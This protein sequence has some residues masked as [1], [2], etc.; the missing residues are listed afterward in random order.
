MPFV[1]AQ[2]HEHQDKKG[3]NDCNKYHTKKLDHQL[4]LN[5]Q[6]FRHTKEMIGCHLPASF[7]IN[8]GRKSNVQAIEY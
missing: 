5:E 8:H 1:C 3:R 4:E 2:G 6:K 7:M